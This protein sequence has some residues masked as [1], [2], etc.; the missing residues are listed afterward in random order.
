MI[1]HEFGDDDDDFEEGE[2]EEEIEVPEVD[3]EERE[4]QFFG[5]CYNSI[6]STVP[7]E[8]EIV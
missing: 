4:R 5:E 1:C 7:E 6:M 2:E 3:D 8:D